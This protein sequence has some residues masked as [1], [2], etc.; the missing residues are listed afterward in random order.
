LD[1][2]YSKAILTA[3]IKIGSFRG[4]SQPITWFNKIF[5]NCFLMEIRSKNRYSRF[6]V[7]DEMGDLQYP[8]S[9]E[10]LAIVRQ[11]LALT[12]NEGG[13]E[14]KLFK[15]ILNGYTIKEIGEVLSISVAGAKSRI[16]RARRRLAN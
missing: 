10:K 1:E 12:L 7:I 4:E 11:Q 15:M 3:V 9:Q 5:I 2:V 14:E 13:E 16:H 8:A 6:I